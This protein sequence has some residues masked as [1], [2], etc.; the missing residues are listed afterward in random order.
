M[1]SITRENWSSGIT[2]VILDD[3]ESGN[4]LSEEM[5]S[6]FRQQVAAIR[7]DPAV[8]VV[9]IEGRGPLFSAGGYV[10]LLGHLEDEGPSIA[11][12]KKLEAFYA[13]F[14]SLRDLEVPVIAALNG[15]A[16]GAG[17]GLAL[18]CDLRIATD[19]AKLGFNFVRFG[20]HPGMGVTY[21]LPRLLGP[22]RAAH[23]LY[24]GKIITAQEG[25]ELGL[26][27][28]ITPRPLFQEEVYGLAEEIAN[29]GSDAVKDLKLTLRLTEDVILPECLRREAECQARQLLRNEESVSGHLTDSQRLVRDAELRL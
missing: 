18:A 24:S 12:R 5:A 6:E 27:N 23:L 1:P 3:Q 29:V 7:E 26:L 16:I 21:F 15:S 28:K 8:R 19:D 13:Q 4:A 25:F 17:L 11:N 9:V 22:T 20:L 14:L 2:A 10:E